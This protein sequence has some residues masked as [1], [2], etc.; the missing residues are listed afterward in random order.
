MNRSDFYGYMTGKSNDAKWLAFMQEW[1]NADYRHGYK[2]GLRDGQ[3]VMN[4]LFDVRPDLYKYATAT[5]FDPFYKDGNLREF[6]DRIY[7]R[8]N[9]RE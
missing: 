6:G 7:E 3:N 8:W 4:A 9:E 1:V 2:P 5:T